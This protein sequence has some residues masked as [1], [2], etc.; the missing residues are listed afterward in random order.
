[1]GDSV[2]VSRSVS[3]GFPLLLHVVRGMTVITSALAELLRFLRDFG[4]VKLQTASP[5]V[6]GNTWMIGP[7]HAVWGVEYY[8][9]HSWCMVSFACWPLVPVRAHPPFNRSCF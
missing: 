3:L 2:S 6:C 4:N 9:N 8:A 5:P 1:M 7:K